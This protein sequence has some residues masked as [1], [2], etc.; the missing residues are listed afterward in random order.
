MALMATAP[1]SSKAGLGSPFFSINLVTVHI[2]AGML[3][4][5]FSNGD[6]VLKVMEP[7][8]GTEYN[9]RMMKSGIAKI[10]LRLFWQMVDSKDLFNAVRVKKSTQNDHKQL[11]TRVQDSGTKCPKKASASDVRNAAKVTQQSK[12]TIRWNTMIPK[13]TAVTFLIA[14]GFNAE[15][16]PFNRAGSGCSRVLRAYKSLQCKV[17]IETYEAEIV[18][19]LKALLMT[20][21]LHSERWCSLSAPSVAI[22][23]DRKMHPSTSTL[24]RHCNPK[25]LKAT[26]SRAM[27]RE[28][29]LS[30]LFGRSLRVTCRVC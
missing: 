28:W 24:R 16:E 12:Q 1:L 5:N 21:S 6:D 19:N 26:Q 10:A 2:C 17:D 18:C 15:N 7:I 23:V 8:I 30:M 9:G 20:R 22:G 11:A 25:G 3:P 29:I 4:A 13:S 14:K 27:W